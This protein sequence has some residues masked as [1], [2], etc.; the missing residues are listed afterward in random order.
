M[1]S[2]TVK[3]TDNQELRYQVERVPEG[4]GIGCD[5]Y[6]DGEKVGEC[7]WSVDSRYDWSHESDGTEPTSGWPLPP[8]N[9]RRVALNTP[10]I[11]P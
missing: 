1:K 4:W 9:L 11:L 2:Q 8:L 7:L 10:D 5:F 6:V 3:L